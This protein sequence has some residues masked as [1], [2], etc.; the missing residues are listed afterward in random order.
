MFIVTIKI[1]LVICTT[2]SIQNIIVCLHG[3]FSVF[4]NNKANSYMG[5]SNY[6]YRRLEETLHMCILFVQSVTSSYKYEPGEN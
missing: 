5:D 4:S 3:V 1:I 6:L 2:C